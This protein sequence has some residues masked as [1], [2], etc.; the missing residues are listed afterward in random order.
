MSDTEPD[1]TPSPQ[2]VAYRDAGEFNKAMDRAADAIRAAEGPDIAGTVIWAALVGFQAFLYVTDWVFDWEVREK[3]IPGVDLAKPLWVL[4]VGMV[5]FH[6]AWARYQHGR[7]LKNRLCLRCGA[8]LLEV[9]VD[10]GG[11]GTC[12]KCRRA[13]NLGEYRRPDE[14]RGRSFAGYIDPSHFD[15]AMYAASEHLKK[16]R[17][18]GLEGEVIGWSWLAL[19]VS[20]GCKVILGWNLLEWLPGSHHHF[21]WLVTM[22]AWSGI[23]AW[24]VQRMRP[25]I[26]ERRLCLN[27]GY[28]L[29]HTPTGEDG[30]GRC[31][32]CGGEFAIGQY[33]R[34]AETAPEG[35]S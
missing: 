30:I 27:C 21:L 23:Y 28:S 15:K 20:F 8:K 2:R 4:I 12:P 5:L 10:E 34:P 11:S 29:L 16:A 35:D 3:I 24:R 17:L 9:E 14:N 32:E 33:E 26:A 1:A 25:A 19:G 13:F 7:I 6:H 18:F 31:P 22:L